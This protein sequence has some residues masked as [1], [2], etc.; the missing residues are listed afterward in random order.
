MDYGGGY[1]IFTRMMRDLGW[2]WLWYDKYSD[3]LA[4]RGFEYETDKKRKS[5]DLITAFELFEHLEEPLK[6]VEYLLSISRNILFSTECYDEGY[7]YKTPA[8]WW[9]YS[10]NTGQHISFYSK[11][12]LEYLAN[13]HEV[14]YYKISNGLHLFTEERMCEWKLKLL[15][16]PKLQFMQY[17]FYHKNRRKCLAFADMNELYDRNKI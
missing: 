5:I 2:N 15:V 6:E 4:A 16:N 8:D 1:G 13:R 9:Y 11:V 17:Y 12:T 3:N 7:E 10:L 14:Y